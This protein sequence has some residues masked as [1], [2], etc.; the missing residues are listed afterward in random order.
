M[1]EGSNRLPHLLA[2]I[3]NANVVFAQA[4]KTTAS[5]AFI[6]GKSLIEAKDLC[7]HGDWTGFLKEAGL[8]PRTAQRYMRLVQS[9]F[10]SEYI[11]LVGVTEALKEI[12]EAQEIM[13]SD[14]KAI[15]AVWEAEPTPDT[16]MWWRIDRHTGG[17][18]QANTND[19]DPDVATVLI[20]HSMPI[21]FIAFIVD[22][23]SNG[24][25]WDQPRQQRFRREVTMQERD[26]KIAF[27]KEEAARFQEARK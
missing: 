21:V 6:M 20:V 22:V 14:G 5:A 3:K 7:G 13:P 18:F 27:V 26:E 24:L 2:E 25:M 1:T 10:G 11:G 12:D 19:D 8:P 4:Q 9:G 15:M 23:F 17:F 16:M